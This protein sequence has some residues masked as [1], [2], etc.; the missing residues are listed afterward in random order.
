MKE[1]IRVENA[2]RSPAIG[3]GCGKDVDPKGR[4]SLSA[5]DPQGERSSLREAESSSRSSMLPMPEH[6]ARW[7]G[8]GLWL[9]YGGRLGELAWLPGLYGHQTLGS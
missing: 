6:G 2:S 4:R 1:A 7:M 5:V 3:R 9:A 8:R